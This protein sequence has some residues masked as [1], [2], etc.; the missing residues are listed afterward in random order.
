MA[1]VAEHSAESVARRQQQQAAGRRGAC[2]GFDQPVGCERPR[3][4]RG[5][6]SMGMGLAAVCF[7][8]TML[9]GAEGNFLEERHRADRKCS[10]APVEVPFPF[11]LE[12]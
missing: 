11:L 1:E 2:H 8:A 7:A 6:F 5:R 3:R 10:L 9:G 4:G 12:T